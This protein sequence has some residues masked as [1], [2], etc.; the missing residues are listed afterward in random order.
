MDRWER[1]YWKGLGERS[2]A[3]LLAAVQVR[4][5]Y[6]LN[7]GPGGNKC[8]I[9]FLGLL[10]AQYKK[11]HSVQWMLPT[12]RHHLPHRMNLILFPFHLAGFLQAQPGVR[13]KRPKMA[14]ICPALLWCSDSGNRKMYLPDSWMEEVKVG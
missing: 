8:W 10:S 13:C 1:P 11:K 6:Q 14:Q 12:F 3:D 4:L 9:P 2:L 5:Q 7:H